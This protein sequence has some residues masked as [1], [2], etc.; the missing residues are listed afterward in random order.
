MTACG[1][2]L[3]FISPS[4]ASLI[5]GSPS[6]TGVD[7]LI[8]CH[9][10]AQPRQKRLARLARTGAKHREGIGADRRGVAALAGV[11]RAGVVDRDIAAAEAGLQHRCVLGAERLELGRQQADDLPL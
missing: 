5:T 4:A 8:E 6:K 7:A 1:S 11:A 9:A 10:A 3:S 2:W